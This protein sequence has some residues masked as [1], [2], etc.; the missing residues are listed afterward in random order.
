MLFLLKE[1]L[2]KNNQTI[3]LATSTRIGSRMVVCSLLTNLLVV[4]WDTSSKKQD[5]SFLD[6]FCALWFKKVEDIIN[7]EYFLS[8]TP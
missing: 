7:T 5:G 2:V 1:G 6:L 8:G 4:L 3:Q